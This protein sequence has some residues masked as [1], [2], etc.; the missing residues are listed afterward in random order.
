MP[1]WLRA[2]VMSAYRLRSLRHLVLRGVRWMEGRPMM[3]QTHRALLQRFHGV[4]VGNFSYGDIL[5]PGLLPPGTTVGAYCSV[6]TGLIVRRRD[7]PVDRP[8]MHAAFYNAAL[9]FVPRDAIPLDTDNP[10]NI[11]HD[12]WIG[13]R[14][15]IL[16]GCR[17]IGNGAVLAAGTV[18][19]SDVPA[20][21]IVGGVPAR[22]IRHRFSEAETTR[23][24][25]STWWDRPLDQIIDATDLPDPFAPLPPT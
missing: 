18:V 23:L 24:E 3:S 5:T 2:L 19:T 6:G 20:Y 16:G 4:S 12:V 10:L 25:A 15:T 13:D 7:H 14:V 22:P 17:S 21:M 8:F 9:G 11:G 1:S